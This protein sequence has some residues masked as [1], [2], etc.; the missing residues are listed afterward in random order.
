MFLKTIKGKVLLV[1]ALIMLGLIVQSVFIVA[2]TN[3]LSD[4]LINDSTAQ[5]E[6]V[7]K[8][9]QLKIAVIQVQQWLQDISS[10][11]GLDGLDDGFAMAEEQAA[12]ARQLLQELISLNPDQADVYQQVQPNFEEYFR[13]GKLMAQAYVDFG[14]EAGNRTM[15]QFDEAAE[16]IT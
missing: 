2:K 4:S 1:S 6:I 10:T 16:A 3:R 8:S 7:R 12:I 9:Y 11:R 15:P 13:I 14:P 5:S